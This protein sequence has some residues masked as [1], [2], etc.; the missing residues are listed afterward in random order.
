V[1][2]QA[3]EWKSE[4]GDEYHKRSPGDVSANVR[5]FYGALEK[6]PPMSAETVC[7]YGCG[8]GANL[9]ALEQ[10]VPHATLFGVEINANAAAAAKAAMP[11]AS[12]VVANIL[13]GVAFDAD[14]VLTKGVL[15]HIPPSYLRTAYRTLYD[16]ARKYILMAEYFC[17]T[18][19]MIPY[20]GKDNMLWAGPHAYQMLDDYSD[21]SI[22]DYGFAS[23]RDY[24]PQDDLTWFLLEKG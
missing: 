14:L 23:K 17:P 10:V 18:F 24:Y 13:D 6:V 22:L 21:L 3:K 20:R 4:F 8:T 11:Y 2:E 5:F 9:A 19:R 7:E 12:I 15:I 16:S 1:N